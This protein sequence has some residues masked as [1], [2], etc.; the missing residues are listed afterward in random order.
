[1]AQKTKTSTSRKKSGSS[2][3]ASAS[4]RK[5]GS[6][7]SS[8]RPASSTKTYSGSRSGS[9]RKGSSSKR[10]S[11]GTS[12]TRKAAAVEKARRQNQIRE[13]EVRMTIALVVML[14]AM[15]F[16]YMSLAGFG[17][18]VG[19][20]LGKILYGL[21]GI[22]A[23]LLPVWL[24]AFCS[25]LLF[26]KGGRNMP[27]RLLA[28]A[29]LILIIQSVGHLYLHLSG[30][31]S[32]DVPFDVKAAFR[33][34]AETCLGGGIPGGW[35]SNLMYRAF[36][37]TGSWLVYVGFLLIALM[38][39]F[40]RSP[41]GI[42]R[43]WREYREEEGI[44]GFSE[45]RAIRRE[46][47]RQA[48]EEEEEE[49]L[50]RDAE[51]ILRRE[52]RAAARA[53]KRQLAEENSRKR[54]KRT[55]ARSLNLEHT[56][57]VDGS[58]TA[59]SSKK[60]SA[61]KRSR[62]RIN[63]MDR[64]KDVH[65]IVVLPEDP[66]EEAAVVAGKRRKDGESSAFDPSRDRYFGAE[67]DFDDFND[68]DDADGLNVFDDDH[69]S[70]KIYSIPAGKRGTA[71]S[72][73]YISG[74]T[75]ADAFAADLAAGK[76]AGAGADSKTGTADASALNIWP[77]A[78]GKDNS[79]DVTGRPERTAGTGGF[80]DRPDRAAGA[81]GT[82]DR[83]DRA[84]GAA[85]YTN[86][87]DRAAGAA[88]YTNGSDMP[89]IA[90]GSSDGP[91]R[92]GGPAGASGM[93]G[94][95]A[96]PGTG[97]IPAAASSSR[98]GGFSTPS[99]EELQGIAVHREPDKSGSG[100]RNPGRTAAA[101][102]NSSYIAPTFSLLEKGSSGTNDE[103]EREL[104]ETAYRLQE[105]LRTFGVQ[106]TITDISQGPSV[107]RYELKPDK[108][109]KVSKIVNLSDDIKLRLAATDIRIEAPIPGKSAI[110][111]EVPNK[112]ETT[113]HLRELLE[114]REFRR[115]EGKLPFAVGKD[116]GGKTVIADIAR[117][118]HLLIAG[119]TGS[120]KSVCINTIILSIL[121]RTSPENVRLLMIDPKV[122]ELSVYKK[123]PHLIIPVVTDARKA[124]AAL[125]WAVAEME[126]RYKLFAAA[127]ARDLNGYNAMAASYR[128][129]DGELERE[130]L[131]RI[132]IIVDELADLMMVAKSEVES[133]ICRLAQ[134]ARAAGIH[135]IIATQRPSVDVITGLI[136]ANMPSRIAF[137]V[138]SQV[139][140]R[141]I[142]D[143]A[144]AEKL[145]GRGDMLFFPQNYQKPARIQGAFVSDDE[146]T[147]VVDYIKKNNTAE[148]HDEEVDRQIEDIVVN[149]V[150]G[151]SSG[152]VKTDPGRDEY[153]VE[154]GRFIIEKNKASIGL[155]QRVF[156]IGFN[157]AARIMD[158][159]AEAGVVS[160]ESSTRARQVLMTM[161]EFEAYLENEN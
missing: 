12:G 22:G 83:S 126:K 64:R 41:A 118:P 81:E 55:G 128:N 45:R 139:D 92:E 84:A 2:S 4:R 140:S 46:R 161:P 147:K 63:N 5:P 101:R 100:L 39:F 27:V 120:G 66:G 26:Q 19:A 127:G 75:G 97:S 134:L 54:R 106:V 38:L 8:G 138:S 107:T 44:P 9:G 11:S 59:K 85:G 51:R 89:V 25:F 98:N 149:G 99:E 103:T 125:N 158:Q 145:I 108:G 123:I 143:M 33:L 52:D 112:K 13:R 87:T 36:G 10:T 148:M 157:R 65:E 102:K 43:S 74:H 6:G 1:M 109:V 72:M 77:E 150:P 67:T 144:G 31:T 49:R 48:L 76:N 105:T 47:R 111:I 153:F 133:A 7:K 23:W 90:A 58:G 53:Q 42:L 80:P 154:A 160:E 96:G 29:L 17:G 155:L 78:A 146:V 113:V 60:Q 70:E 156:K 159:L 88:G 104:K 18:S 21:F 24:F 142:L 15:A 124:S 61:K 32:L 94:I 110:G 114:S 129:E 121:Y 91:D 34:C 151:T 56:L 37:V 79:A 115:F 136:K 117:M 57:L 116:I 30:A 14:I 3:A 132:V 135:L 20:A 137:A 69:A 95:G 119:A 50:E 130:P 141:T 131:P 40:Q 28:S 68:F 35:F 122:V 152:E 16:I 62:G 71:A 73:G 93:T 86:G 82:P